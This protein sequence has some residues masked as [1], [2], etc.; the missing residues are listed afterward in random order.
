[1]R[2]VALPVLASFGLAFAALAGTPNFPLPAPWTPHGAEKEAQC[3]IQTDTYRVMEWG[4]RGGKDVLGQGYATSHIGFMFAAPRWPRIGGEI[5][6]DSPR[7]RITMTQVEGMPATAKVPAEGRLVQVND[8]V[9]FVALTGRNALDYMKLLMQAGQ[10]TVTLPSGFRGF[11]PVT[12]QTNA[13][14]GAQAYRWYRKYC[15][16]WNVR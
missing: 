7:V 13:R 4:I 1:M 14:Q 16:N 8:T 9:Y 15:D 11:Q 5:R 6:D 10:I 2:L 3:G 12:F